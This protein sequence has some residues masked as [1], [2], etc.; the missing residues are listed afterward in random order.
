MPIRQQTAEEAYLAVLEQAGCSMPNRDSIDTRIMEE[1]RTGT[2]TYGDN[3]IVNNP[4]EVGGWPALATG[5]P[6]T[7]SDHDG[8]ADSWEIENGLNPDDP[9]DRNKTD[10]IGYTMLENFL[11]SID[12]L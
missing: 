12:N 6:Y 4:S 2:A 1:V 9:S 8:M 3:G 10:S 7:D 11:N 5:T